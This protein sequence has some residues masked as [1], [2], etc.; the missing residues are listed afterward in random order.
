MAP[1]GHDAGHERV[2]AS[3]RW[4]HSGTAQAAQRISARFVLF[5]TLQPVGNRALLGART[6]AGIQHVT[7]T[8]FDSE[9]DPRYE[10]ESTASALGRKESSTEAHRCLS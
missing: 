8:K 5:I 4:N 1:M 9:E 6:C 10:A 3:H 7:E 2:R